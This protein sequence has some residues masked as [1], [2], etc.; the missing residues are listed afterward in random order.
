MRLSPRKHQKKAIEFITKNLKARGQ[1]IWPCGTGKTF[2][3]IKIEESLNSSKSLVFV[4]SIAL[5]SQFLDV[6]K[7]QT[8]HPKEYLC[9][10]S[11]KDVD[12]DEAEYADLL[13]NEG[14]RVT[15]DVDIIK[16]FV[17]G[18]E[19][20]IIFST[21]Q[22]SGRIA[23]ANDI[24]YDFMICDEAHKTAGLKNFQFSIC[25]HDHKIMAKQRL[26][27]TATPRISSRKIKDKYV[28]ATSMDDENLYGPELVRM[29]FTEAIARKLLVDYKIQ[30]VLI[31]DSSLAD[32]IED[33][34]ET[35]QV[36]CNHALVKA[37]KDLGFHHTIT[38]HKSIKR[39]EAFQ[40]KQI[41]LGVNALHVNSKVPMDI[42]KERVEE[43][44]LADEAVL[45]NAKCLTEGIDIP[46]C[47]SVMFV[48]KKNSIVDIVQAA[49][50]PLRLYE[51]KELAHIIVPIWK[52]SSD[53]ADESN[54]SQIVGVLRA[55]GD[56]DERIKSNIQDIMS[57]ANSGKRN[58]HDENDIIRISGDVEVRIRDAIFI[59]ALNRGMGNEF[60]PYE[61]AKIYMHKVKLKS[62]KE[63]KLWDR[64]YFIPSQPDS[65]YKEW[66]GMHVFLGCKRKHGQDF[67]PYE[68][69]KAYMH[70]IGLKSQVAWVRWRSSK[71]SFIP[72]LPAIFYKKEWE[73]M[74]EFLG[75][76]RKHGQ[77]FLPYE[78]AKA[79][80]LQFGLTSYKEFIHWDGRPSFIPS[81]PYRI[82]KKEWKGWF[83]F[84]GY[85]S[86]VGHDFLPYPEAKAYMLKVGLKA[87]GDWTGWIKSGSRPSFIPSCPIDI[88]KKE[89]RGMC[90]FLGCKQ[91]LRRNDYKD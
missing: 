36:A 26:F 22:S 66:E 17:R 4:P 34:Y 90:E 78:E 44:E 77:D 61:E 76:K 69:A 24:H 89:W 80:M 12:G 85:K 43:F 38:F 30:L 70:K 50:R 54:H 63:F 56:Q 46:I 5:L 53:Q 39:A 31:N 33:D 67:L 7:T 14:S 18:K 23:E 25:L 6:W 59:E 65:I 8:N 32:A 37:K 49:G 51:G 86:K 20:F 29:S 52:D 10:C 47:D 2:T 82:Y 1:L 27:M 40:E 71:P 11:D 79:Y 64:P 15:T 48:D 81:C 9:V 88:Y 75:Y 74:P 60:L 72:S 28:T 13:A 41:E 57:R 3:A 45:T 87:A 21:Y 84:L 58:I 35:F 16:K 19:R 91:H 62:W 83:E 68:E 73:G 55:L 42:R